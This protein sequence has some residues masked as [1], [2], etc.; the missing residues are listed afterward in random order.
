MAFPTSLSFTGTLVD[1]D[2]LLLSV[3]FVG[4]FAS[5]GEGRPPF[6]SKVLPPLLEHYR[7]SVIQLLLV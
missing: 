1:I 4:F 5:G 3:S 6:V 7:C 2:I